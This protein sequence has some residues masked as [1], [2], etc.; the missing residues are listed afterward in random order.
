MFL[1]IDV[2]VLEL[3]VYTRL[4]LNSEIHLFLLPKH[5]D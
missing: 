2:A 4:A 5:W 3:T 1:Y